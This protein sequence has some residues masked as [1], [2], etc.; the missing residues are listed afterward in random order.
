MNYDIIDILEFNFT[1]NNLQRAANRFCEDHVF[2][3]INERILKLNSTAKKSHERIFENINSNTLPKAFKKYKILFKLNTVSK[4][5]FSSKEFKNLV[6]GLNYSEPELPSIYTSTSELVQALNL[7]DEVWRDSYFIGLLDCYL[8]NW[9][10]LKNP[11]S[12]ELLGNF[13]QRKISQYTGNRKIIGAIRQNYK[14]FS[15]TN[16]DIILGADFALSNNPIHE[17]LNFLSLPDSW[18]KY[19]YFSKVIDAYY[20]KKKAFLKD[21]INDMEMIFSL[22]NRIETTKRTLSKIIIQTNAN[23][24]DSLIGRIKDTSFKFIGDPELKSGWYPFDGATEFEKANLENAQTIVNDW[25]KQQFISVFF[26]KCINDRRRKNFW[27]RFTKEIH[28]FRIVGGESVAKL[29]KNDQRIKNLVDARFIKTIYQSNQNSAILLSIRNY[30]LVEFSDSGAF[31]AYK[32]MN[33][34]APKLDSKKIDSISNLKVTSMPF[35]FYR[36][37]R[38]VSNIREEGRQSHMDGD[39][40]WETAFEY[41]INKVLNVYA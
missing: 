2:Q 18:L 3:R 34:R 22:H 36:S 25:I 13:L 40:S 7:F 39:L 19:P 4:N 41:W 29:L 31:Y 24:D 17:I 27:L 35:L 23:G 6:Y 12:F 16:G 10:D 15:P 33:P 20:E 1:V 38:Y 28:Q 32:V 11:N 9:Q 14:Y 37:G 21:I 8:K 30:V 5:S 26:E